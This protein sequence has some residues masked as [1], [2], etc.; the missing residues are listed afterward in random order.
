M[1]TEVTPWWQALKIRPEIIDSDGQIDDVQMSLFQAVHGVGRLRP[2]YA[3]AVYYGEITFPTDNLVAL[4]TEI[5]VRVG[6][7]EDFTKAR[8][9]T[10]LDQGM[11]GGKSHACIG[12]YHLAAHPRALAGTDLGKAVFAQ[13]RSRLGREVP[14]DLGNPIAVVLA[15]DNMTPGAPE[16][17]LDGPARSLYE[18]FL[19]RLFGADY[20]LFDRYRPFFNNKAKIA[21]AL[22]AV[23]RP[24]L[25]IIDEIMNYLGNASDKDTILAGQD[26]EFLRALLDTINDVPN[27]AA[28]VVMISS[29]Q[30]PMAQSA[31]AAE[32]RADVNSLLERNGVPATVTSNADFAEILRRRLFVQSPPREVIE[33]TSRAFD[34]I[35][36]D[37]AWRKT[38]WDALGARWIESFTVDVARTYPF[39]PHLMQLA[40]Q[41]WAQVAGFQKVRSTIRIFAA[42]VYALQERGVRGDWVPTLVGPGD[43]PLSNNNVREAILGS[44]LVSDERS[45]ANYRALAENEIVNH[46]DTAGTAHLLDL[47]RGAVMWGASNPRAAE[48]ASTMVFLSSIVGA[49]PGGRRGTSSVEAKA[50]TVVPD[51][52]YVVAD[53]DGVIEELVDPDRG[54]S[55]LEVI[56]GQGNNKPARYFLSTRLTYRMLVNNLRKTITDAERDATLTEFAEAISNTGPFKKKVFVAANLD[57]TATQVLSMAGIDDAR[58][59]RLVVLD[60]AQFSLRNGME[61]D[62]LTALTIAAGLGKG[63]DRLPV[64][65]ASSAVFAVVNTQRRGLARS[66]ATEYLAR[67]RALSTPEVQGNEELKTAGSKERADAKSRL[68]KALRRAYQHIVY[69]SQPTPD[70]PRELDQITFDDDNQT[71]LNGTQVWKALVERD[72]AFDVGQFS[73]KALV[74]NLRDNDYARPLSEVRDA[75]WN[76][77]RLPLLYGG[78]SDLK[79]AIYQAVAAG[80]LCINDASGQPVAVTDASQVNLASTGLRLGRPVTRE[81]IH[82]EGANEH[83]DSRNSNYREPEDRESPPAPAPEADRDVDHPPVSEMYVSFPLVGSLIDD[84]GKADKLAQ[85]FRTLYS[86][87]DDEKASYAQGT[88][89]FVMNSDA[90]V[91]LAEQVKE[92]GLSVQIRDQ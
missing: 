92:L 21:E 78:E 45:I 81:K 48:R 31:A 64:E 43:L 53:A 79:H 25:V 82:P 75:F 29:D 13:A 49:R 26:V 39:H 89:Q 5:V 47:S 10:R 70:V 4:L 69:V 56:P 80:T 46:D 68:D 34:G 42:T 62:T 11:G 23:N 66:Y 65:W 88:L 61:K 72:K 37:R 28:L 7:G 57:L 12:A 19:W 2:E 17:P 58:T 67:E 3:D 50:A 1:S 51:L 77:P 41:E 54:M 87:L 60:P 14:A 16:E 30:D 8:A 27:V 74:H 18:R 40:E 63:S 91:R 24:V 36:S 55:A 33:A 71:A 85:I 32:R 35:H 52:N 15:C 84:Q 38:V 44:G 22:R 76:A 83:P 59:T 20:S 6:S 90:A 9:L 73:S 86:I